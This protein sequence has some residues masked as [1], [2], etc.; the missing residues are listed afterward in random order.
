M[1]LG[2]QNLFFIPFSFSSQLFFLGNIPKKRKQKLVFI[3]I[4]ELCADFYI[5]YFAILTAVF[6]LKAVVTVFRYFI[7]M[8]CNLFG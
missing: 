4:A 8:L 7:Y 6:C 3:K 5:N 2:L 1:S